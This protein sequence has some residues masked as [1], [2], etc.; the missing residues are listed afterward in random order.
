LKAL[1]ILRGPCHAA[2]RYVFEVF[3]QEHGLSNATV[4]RLAQDHQ[5]ALWV[6]TENGL[7]RYDGHR[8][9][10]FTTSEGLPGDKITAIHESPD[11]ILWV[12]TLN[13]LAWKEGA[14]F[15]K[16]TNDVLKGYINLQGIASDRTG[17]VFIATRRGIAVT[18]H[19]A[20]G[21]DME[22]TFLP[23]PKSVPERRSSSV[24]VGSSNEVWFDCDVAIC[25]WDGR[26]VRVWNS[27]AGVPPERWDFLLKDRAGNL[28]ARNREFFIELPTGADHF[29][30]LGPDLPGPLPIPPELAIDSKGRILVTT[31]HGVVIGIPGGWRRV[32]EKQGLPAN[33]VT[34]FLEDAEGSMWLGTY[35]RGL[36]RW[37][38]Y[39]A[40]SGFTEIEGLASSS[41][42]SLLEDPPS[43]M[44]A[45]TLAGLSHGVSSN[46]S[47]SWSEISIPKVSWASSLV[48]SK[49][50]A[51]WMITDRHYVVRYDPASHASRRLG[52]FG[53]G[54]FHLRI[55]SAGRLWIADAG[56]VSVGGTESRLED[57]D[58]IRPPGS[59]AG[60]AFTTTVVDAGGNLWIGSYSGLFLRS[61]GKWFRFD[62]NSGLRA[63]RIRDLALSP[64]GELWVAYAEPKGL[65]RVHLTGATLQVEHFDRSKGL[66]SEEVNSI[67]FDRLGRLWILN[68]HGAEVRRG[69]TWVQFS[70]AD[71]LLA[72]GS[73]GRAFWAGAD[74]TI[75]IGSERGLSWY[76]AADREGAH[77]QPLRVRFSE[78]RIGNTPLDPESTSFVEASPQV[79][80][81]KFSALLLA[82]ASD[83][84]YRYRFVGFDDR[85]QETSLPE[86]RLEYPPPGQYRLDV[87]GRLGSQPW[88]EPGAT[89]ALQVRPRWYQTLWTRGTLVALACALLWLLEH[90]RR[91]KVALSG[92]WISEPPS[93]EG[94]KNATKPRKWRLWAVWQPE[95]RTILTTCLP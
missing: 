2:E 46:G 1:A 57:F 73:N 65:D 38:G 3:D 28:W 79:F 13:G 90:F 78:I 63:N 9:L 85:W 23:W 88:S 89:F 32:T 48:R 59:T 54:P 5:G 40:W 68:D 21:N 30:T 82:H 18:S 71:G 17:R 87:Q 58:R 61:E 70:R 95:S 53:T 67:D 34:A 35:G 56:S 19:P 39:D 10:R 84:R 55:D 43:G 69:D 41:I 51:L 86:V 31:I 12:G 80:E 27:Q 92:S 4:T 49:D 20:P 45:G 33:Y 52:P 42:V 74:G 75:W 36:V 50:G 22:V 14:G 37:A 11:G 60:T 62:T 72:S 77:D 94:A 15:R 47:W 93:C 44:W 6:G 24:Y 91:K 25:L 29:Q 8:F 81:A 83:V 7:Y 76:D 16:A 26:D 66:T 64:E